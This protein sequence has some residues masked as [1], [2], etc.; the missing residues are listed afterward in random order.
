[1]SIIESTV[2]RFFM[3][4]PLHS[5]RRHSGGR[6]RNALQIT[7]QVIFILRRSNALSPMVTNHH[8]LR[9]TKL[10]V[11]CLVYVMAGPVLRA[12]MIRT[13]RFVSVQRKRFYCKGRSPWKKTASRKRT[14]TAMTSLMPPA[15]RSKA[16]LNGIIVPWWSPAKTPYT[17]SIPNAVISSSTAGT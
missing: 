12:D 16:L 11:F 7:P 17:W 10:H 15:K 4:P 14:C 6:K 13:T 1:M 3:P 5:D 2:H 8:V 9:F